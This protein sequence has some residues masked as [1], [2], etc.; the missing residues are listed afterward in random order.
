MIN[1]LRRLGR[2]RTAFKGIPAIVMLACVTAAVAVEK[3]PVSE[4]TP[5]QSTDKQRPPHVVFMIGEA[6]YDTKTSLPEFAQKELHPRGFRTTFVHVNEKDANDF[7]GLEALKSADLLVISVRRRTPK[8]AQLKAVRDY[9]NSRRPVIGLRTASHAFDQKPPSANHAAWPK[10]DDEIFGGDYQGHYGNKPP[11]GPHTLIRASAKHKSHP[12]LR[13]VPT[14]EFRVTSHLYRNRN[15]AAST[16]TLLKGRVDGREKSDEPVAWINERKG[17]RIFYTSLGD[18]K[19]FRIAAFRRMLR[20]AIDWTTRHPSPEPISLKLQ[21]RDVTTG[22]PETSLEEFDPSRVG[23]VVVDMWNWHWCKTATERVASMVPRMERSLVACRKLGIQVFYCPTD[24]VDAYVGTPQREAVIAMRL[25]ALPKPLNI[26]CPAPPNGP[27]CACGN[28]KCRGNFGWDAMHPGL[29]IHASDLMPNSRES[30]YSICKDKNID[31]LIYMGVHTQVCLLGKSVGLR[32]MKSLGFNCVLARDLTDSH[33]DY[34]PARGIDP[35][36]LTK[37]TVDHFEKYLCATVNM[38]DELQRLGKW[39]D[40]RPVDPVRLAP[41]GTP[42]RPHLFDKPVTLTLSAPWQVGASIHYTTDGS[43]PTSKA[44]RYTKPLSIT[45][46]TRLRAQ[47]FYQDKPVSL[48]TVG[49]YAKLAEVPPQPD[50]HLGDT[51]PKRVV[52]PGHS[53]DDAHHRFSANG[54]PPKKDQTVEGKPLRLADKVFKRGIGVHA[55]NQLIYEIKPEYDRFVALT[56]VDEYLLDTSHGTNLARHP[57]VTFRVFIDG[58][59]AA[60]SPVMRISFEPWR[61][62][63]KIPKGAKLISLCATDAGNGSKQDLANW[64]NVGFVRKPV[65]KKD[66]SK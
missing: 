53:Y 27:G 17:Q 36:D 61:F 34:D 56:G 33:P 50:V 64:V 9:I 29:S 40:N 12:I 25:L 49:Y 14:D 16:T 22:K 55:P 23:I 66:A 5:L 43:P 59:L 26:Q 19:D 28:R 35:D 21:R 8:N 51:A 13:G 63:V 24:A 7:Q 1:N 11:N 48:E 65:K 37:R 47:A 31:T 58:R 3:A 6:E 54:G 32:N 62:D 4:N 60:E 15:L 20:N 30:L 41:W 45:S 38:K 44:K 57:S 10:F 2:F 52:G 39:P 18:P 46:T 42:M